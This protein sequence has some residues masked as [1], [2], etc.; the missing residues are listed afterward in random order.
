MKINVMT[1][2]YNANFLGGSHLLLGE[3]KKACNYFNKPLAI[4]PQYKE[5]L[6][7]LKSL[8]SNREFHLISRAHYVN[9]IQHVSGSDLIF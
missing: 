8:G 4:H 2:V 7:N 5:P 6:E 3:S 9:F 1:P